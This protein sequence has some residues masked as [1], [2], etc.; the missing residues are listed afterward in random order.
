MKDEIR[1]NYYLAN[2]SLRSAVTTTNICRDYIKGKKAR[3]LADSALNDIE[4]YIK[5]AQ[6]HLKILC[7]L[8]EAQKGGAES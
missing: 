6:E 1:E 2:E 3:A 8:A 5:K 4:E 7:E